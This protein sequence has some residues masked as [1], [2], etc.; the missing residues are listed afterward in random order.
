MIEQNIVT[1][2]TRITEACR[3]VGR[4]PAEVRIVAVSKTVT[5][6]R[7]AEAVQAGMSDIGENRFQE[8]RVKM[9]ALASL[10]VR[11]HFIGHLQSNKVKYL[12][13]NVHLVHSLDSLSAVEQIEKW[14]RK[15]NIP[16][17]A[18]LQVNVS[19][20]QSKFGIEPDE[21]DSFLDEV[22]TCEYLDLA[23]FMTIGSFTDDEERIRREF[24]L[25][26]HIR[27]TVT[28][29]RPERRAMTLLSMGMTDDFEI[30]VEEG[31]HLV[32]IGRALFGE[33]V[34]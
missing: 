21:V 3:R 11:W 18:L 24:R 5:A 31:A 34:I 33:R 16:V 19:G 7:V 13:G 2:K 4:D 32:R 20:E 22:R 1:I 6:D 15:K 29:A 8:L 25:L 27:D 28:A 10:P 9:E 23:G 30:A 14:G 12:V 26:K 17:R